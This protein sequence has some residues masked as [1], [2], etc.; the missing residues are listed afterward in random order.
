MVPRHKMRQLIEIWF[1]LRRFTGR[2]RQGQAPEG[3]VEMARG[4]RLPGG[5][6][7]AGFAALRDCQMRIM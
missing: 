2:F 4:G 6:P 5:E 1:F 7:P 3:M